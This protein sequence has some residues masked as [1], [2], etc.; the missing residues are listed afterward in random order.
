MASRNIWLLGFIPE[1]NID[2]AI[3]QTIGQGLTR[4]G[5][6]LP[7]GAYGERLGRTLD[8]RIARYGGELVLKFTRPM[9]RACL[10]RSAAGAI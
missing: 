1:D 10:S 3:A 2:R 9:H 5:A 8:E 4:F 7:E 6:L